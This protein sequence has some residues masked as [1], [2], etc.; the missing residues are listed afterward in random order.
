MGR[1][2]REP[3]NERKGLL[4]AAHLVKKL[5]KQLLGHFRF[6]VAHKERAIRFRRRRPHRNVAP[7]L[8]RPKGRRRRAHCAL[9]ETPRPRRP[10]RHGRRRRS[11]STCA[12]ELRMLG[13]GAPVEG[14]GYG[15]PCGRGS[16]S[17]PAGLIGAARGLLDRGT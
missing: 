16:G 13:R 3:G 12:D 11:A 4:S 10:G 7:S 17:T 5:E 14:A 15:F 2:T 9:S 6:K 8:K 1:A